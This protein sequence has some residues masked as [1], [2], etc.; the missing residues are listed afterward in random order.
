VNPFARLV[1]GIWKARHGGGLVVSSRSRRVLAGLWVAGLLSAGGCVSVQVSGADSIQDL[2]AE[3]RYKAVYAEQMAKIGVDNRLFAPASSKPGL[4]NVGG[5]QQG[6][7]EADAQLIQDFQV[8]LKALET[9]PVPPRFS[10]ADKLLREAIAEDIRGLELRNQAI[11][12][13]DDAAWTQHKVV[14]QNALAALQQAYQ[15]FPG[16]NRPEPAP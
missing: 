2:G 10:S 6:C 11:A 9:T 5:S 3:G 15:A 1:D 14:L 8:M 7:F 12:N 16:D 13:H 4:C